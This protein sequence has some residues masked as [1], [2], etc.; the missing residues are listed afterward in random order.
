[1]GYRLISRDIDEAGATA[2]ADILTKMADAHTRLSEGQGAELVWRGR[3]NNRLTPAEALKIYALKTAPAFEAAL[4]CGLRLA[5]P[6]DQYAEPSA[7]LAKH[8]V[9]WLPNT[10]GLH[11]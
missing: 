8:L 3:R 7:R 5:G 2:A 10:Q 9:M 4:Y 6:T 11:E 1:M